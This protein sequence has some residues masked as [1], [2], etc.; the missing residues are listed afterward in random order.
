L[1]DERLF[2]RL[3][4][5]QIDI[6]LRLAPIYC[7]CFSEKL[8]DH[9]SDIFKRFHSIMNLRND[10]IHANLTQSMRQAVI[11]EDGYVFILEKSSRDKN[12]LPKSID[13]LSQEDILLIK[14]N[15]DQMIDLLASAMKPRFRKEFKNIIDSEHIQ[16]TI[17]DGETIVVGSSGSF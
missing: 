11:H 17:E 6:K 13:A 1:R 8:I 5:E 15:I 7:E 12:K 16:T 2:D 3:S 10:F 9:E 14:E 4:R